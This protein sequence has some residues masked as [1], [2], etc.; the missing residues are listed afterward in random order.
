MNGL[1]KYSIA[2]ITV[3]I[4]GSYAL[5]SNSNSS[6][7]IIVGSNS[8]SPSAGNINPPKV[9]DT[10]SSGGATV[11]V[12]NPKPKPKPVAGQYQDGTYTGSVADAVY[13]NL[14]VAAVIQGGKLTDVQFLDYP[15]DRGQSIRINSYSSPILREEAIAAQSAQVDTVSGATASSG[16]FRESLASALAQAKA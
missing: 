12:I 16:A 11:A 5:W 3:V 9:T 2:T 6:D 15:Q 14:Q 8:T 7:Q 4:L 10:T 13:G 1:K